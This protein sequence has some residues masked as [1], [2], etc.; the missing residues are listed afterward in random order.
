M[1]TCDICYEEHEYPSMGEPTSLCIKALNTRLA[2][3][4][5]D[6]DHFRGHYD[7]LV[8]ALT[9]RNEARTKLAD[10]EK[11]EVEL[12]EAAKEFLKH[13]FY[14]HPDCSEGK[15]MKFIHA[16]ERLKK[17][18]GMECEAQPEKC[19]GCGNEIDPTTCHCGDTAD[20]D[21]YQAGHSPIPMGCDCG[22]T[23]KE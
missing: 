3:A 13:A 23:R 18:A 19:G 12:I 9:E 7:K 6:R 5:K 11:R 10:V 21:A 20:H 4:E 17:A 22:R 1:N 16:G 15:K 8:L 2:E 14:P